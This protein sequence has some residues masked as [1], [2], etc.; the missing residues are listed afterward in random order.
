MD[1]S[2][3]QAPASLGSSTVQ[4]K[5][6]GEPMLQAFERPLFEVELY[7]KLFITTSGGW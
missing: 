1:W 7:L 2:R 4:S 5:S 3:S 6:I